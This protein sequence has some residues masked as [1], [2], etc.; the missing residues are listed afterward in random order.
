[1]PTRLYNNRDATGNKAKEHQ[2][3]CIQRASHVREGN[4][5]HAEIG[6]RGLCIFRNEERK[7]RRVN[8][9]LFLSLLQFEKSM[10]EQRLLLAQADSEPVYRRDTINKA[11][12][13][14]ITECEGK[15]FKDS[16]LRI[17]LLE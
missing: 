14:L 10:R 12:T 15:T 13:A 7:E 8:R 9:K 6:N 5:F 11:D 3:I 16:A 1:M 4:I 2:N 17:K